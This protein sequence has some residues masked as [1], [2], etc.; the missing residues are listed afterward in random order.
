MTSFFGSVA[1]VKS[2]DL[3]FQKNFRHTSV[4]LKR[5]VKSASEDRKVS[6]SQLVRW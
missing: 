6:H 2:P 5:N 4:N 1:T 3:K